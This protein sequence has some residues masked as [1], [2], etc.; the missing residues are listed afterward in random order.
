[1]S[2]G[3]LFLDNICW[4]FG[5]E[6]RGREGLEAYEHEERESG[7]AHSLAEKRCVEDE[8]LF[9]GKEADLA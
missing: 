2:G 7:G 3:G 4:V 6:S 8:A 9:G 1:M 5:D